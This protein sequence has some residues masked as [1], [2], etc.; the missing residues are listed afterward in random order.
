MTHMRLWPNTSSSGHSRSYRGELR[1]FSLTFDIMNTDQHGWPQRVSIAKCIDWCTTSPT[2]VTMRPLVTL[3]F[4]QPFFVAKIVPKSDQFLWLPEA[5]P[6]F[7]PKQPYW[8][9]TVGTKKASN[10]VR[11]SSFSWRHVENATYAIWAWNAKVNIRHQ[12]KATGWI[13]V[14]F[15]KY[16]DEANTRIFDSIKTSKFAAASWSNNPRQYHEMDVILIV[17]RDC[18]LPLHYNRLHNWPDF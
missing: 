3:T 14:I 2:W 6:H 8:A 15:P 13:K 9:K 5:R 10:I 4:D 17:W 12:V 11:M 16:S 1:F 18:F 7:C